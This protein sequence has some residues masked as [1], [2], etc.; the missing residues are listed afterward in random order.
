M[1]EQFGRL[2]KANVSLDQASEMYMVRLEEK[3]KAHKIEE[4]KE[5]M[6]NKKAPTFALKNLKGEQ[7][8]LESLKGKVVVVDF[9]A[10]W[11]GPCK[12][13]FPGM[14][15]AVTK[16]DK[17]DDVAFVFIDT[18]ENGKKKEEN[19]QKFIDG[20]SYTFNVLMDNDNK[21]VADYEVSGIPTKFILDKEG[22]IR[23]KSTGFNGNDDAL[24]DEISIVVEILRGGDS[25]N[26]NTGAQPY[27][28]VAR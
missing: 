22:N 2:F 10:T 15:K 3:A 4:I 28:K 25:G 16:Y 11:C 8:S 24:V 26:S 27:S 6:M 7:V 14:Q 20:K 9:W 21:M 13:S 17:A 18:W 5:E 19:A 23:F 1:K 12:A